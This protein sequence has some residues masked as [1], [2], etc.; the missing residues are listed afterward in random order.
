V[1]RQMRTEGRV[2]VEGRGPGARWRAT[3]A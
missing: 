1:L 3:P 2:Q